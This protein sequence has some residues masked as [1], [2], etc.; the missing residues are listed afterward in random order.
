MDAICENGLINLRFDT[1]EATGVYGL[2]DIFYFTKA[3][4]FL[5]NI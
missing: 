4:A 5:L 2:N 3:Q 1:V